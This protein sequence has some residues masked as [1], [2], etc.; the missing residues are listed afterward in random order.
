MNGAPRFFPS[1]PVPTLAPGAIRARSAEDTLA[2]LLPLLARFGITRLANITGLDTIGLPVYQAI[3]PTS[4]ALSVAQGKGSD[5][6]TAKVSAVMESLESYHA[7]YA[8]CAVRLETHRAL[9]REARVVDALR[10]PLSRSGRF[11]VDATL[12][13]AEGYDLRTSERLFVP[14]ELVHANFTVPRLSG[15]GA[16]V[17][18]TSGLGAGN[19][20][21]EAALHALCELVERDA[22]TLWRLGG[23]ATKNATRVAVESVDGPASR[24]LIAMFQAAGLEIMIWD[25][26]SD[27]RV[28]CFDVAIFDLES[29]PELNPRPAARGSG[30][31]FDRDVALYR[32]LAEA[33]QSRLTSIAGSRDDLSTLRYRAFQ[34]RESL[35]H[36]RKE[37][38]VPGGR[39]FDLT[40]T[41]P[42]TRTL[43]GDLAQVV[44]RLAERGI[45][46][47]AVV[48][49]GSPDVDLSF[50]R[51]VAVGL[52]G[53]MD[54]PSFM[55]GA[56]ARARVGA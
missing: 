32:A 14:Y 53:T 18:S 46:E 22:E 51:L 1:A 34:S 54:S 44:D 6:T 47:I 35:E 26:T 5:V 39:A 19:H 55:P 29:D 10:L 30:C 45:D 17:A 15:S 31:H 42:S 33:A 21:A 48:D 13:W 40:P 8:R 23:E 56:R 25:Q 11:H 38:A 28:A 20:P 27:V 36:W 7:E 24:A 37:A 2:L 16:F 3:R 52:E 12:P 41:S 4:R 49:L 50:L 43:D 9:S